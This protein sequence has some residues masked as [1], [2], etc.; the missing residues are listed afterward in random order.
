MQFFIQA[1]VGFISNINFL[2]TAESKEE[3]IEKVKNNVKV[4]NYEA[5]IGRTVSFSEIIDLADLQ[6]ID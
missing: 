4:K 3:A 5:H 1:S 2:V 6:T